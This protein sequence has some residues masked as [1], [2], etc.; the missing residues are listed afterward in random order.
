M[1]I[2]STLNKPARVY[3]SP[4]DIHGVTGRGKNLKIPEMVALRI[5]ITGL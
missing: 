4:A 1:I 5:T 3:I 2:S